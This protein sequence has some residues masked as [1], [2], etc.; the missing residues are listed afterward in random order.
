[1]SLPLCGDR[2]LAHQHYSILV[3]QLGL[4]YLF[5]EATECIESEDMQ[6]KILQL[7][8]KNEGYL[9]V[10]KALRER[11]YERMLAL[12]RRHNSIG[13]P[14]ALAVNTISWLLEHDGSMSAFD[15]ARAVTLKPKTSALAAIDVDDVM[16]RVILVC[17]GFVTLDRHSGVA[18]FIHQTCREFLASVDF[19]RTAE[20]HTRMSC[21]ALTYLTRF[22]PTFEWPTRIRVFPDHP[23]SFLV[24][25][26]IFLLFKATCVD[27]AALL[28]FL[29]SL[30][31]RNRAEFV[32]VAYLL[33][34]RARR[35]YYGTHYE[36]YDTVPPSD[37]LHIL[38]LLSRDGP[39]TDYLS[40]DELGLPMSQHTYAML[41]AAATGRLALLKELHHLH[42]NGFDGARDGFGGTALHW[43]AAGGQLSSV[44]W[45]MDQISHHISTLTDSQGLT[46]V[47]L[48]VKNSHTHVV[49][50]LLSKGLNVQTLGR[51]IWD[52][53][54][55]ECMRKGEPSMMKTLLAAS[56]TQFGYVN[57]RGQTLLHLSAIHGNTS[58]LE[59]LLNETPI[60]DRINDRDLRHRTALY[61]A[62]SYGRADI[63]RIL[64]Q[65][66]PDVTL[67]DQKGW[68]PLHAV[69]LSKNISGQQVQAVVI[70]LVE[71]NASSYVQ[72]HQGKTPYHWTRRSQ[73]TVQRSDDVRLLLINNNTAGTSSQNYLELRTSLLDAAADGHDHIAVDA[74]LE[75]DG[76]DI[77]SSAGIE[78][79]VNIALRTRCMA[80]IIWLIREWQPRAPISP[81]DALWRV[82]GQT[83]LQ[84]ALSHQYEGP[85]LLKAL[86]EVSLG[87]VDLAWQDEKRRS[88]LHFACSQM[89]DPHDL[90]LILLE[91]G[92]A[93]HMEDRDDQGMTALHTAITAG[94]S[95]HTVAILVAQ[96][97]ADVGALDG[98]G[99]SCLKLVYQQAVS[100]PPSSKHGSTW[101]I[102]CICIM[103]CLMAHT[104][105]QDLELFGGP[106]LAEACAGGHSWI[107]ECLLQ[108]QLDDNVPLGQAI[109]DGRD[110]MVHALLHRRFY[111]Q[112]A[113]HPNSP[114]TETSEFEGPGF[115]LP[116]VTSSGLLF[117][118]PARPE[119]APVPQIVAES[120]A[121]EGV[122]ARWYKQSHHD[123]KNATL[124]GLWQ[125]HYSLDKA[126]L[127]HYLRVDLNTLLTLKVFHPRRNPWV[128]HPRRDPSATV[129]PWRQVVF[130]RLTD[131]SPDGFRI[132]PQRAEDTCAGRSL[133][134]TSSEEFTG[135]RQV[136]VSEGALRGVLLTDLRVRAT[137]I[138]LA[139]FPIHK[140]LTF[141][142]TM[143]SRLWIRKA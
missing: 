113:Q 100:M 22:N 125:T 33:L 96:A 69:F 120:R 117:V 56:D 83:P 41:F 14:S 31:A 4:D 34:L 126:Y 137:F 92:A 48:A 37:S 32:R 79:L 39:I 16:E 85:L 111:G 141:D 84:I 135:L 35:P 139:T 15:L 140:F 123:S 67:A 131:R 65:H 21:T 40:V 52:S 116:L 109:V 78:T 143:H 28:R 94:Q 11:L 118:G 58:I 127:A 129:T 98:S 112:F 29:R 66:D 72:D 124:K 71:G 105:S 70:A 73:Y 3:A 17:C 7:S 19:E 110:E 68:T 87:L 64:V 60:A 51:T 20:R 77:C 25:V 132:S 101:R 75:R 23:D 36:A 119:P 42:S 99:N 57:L 90:V 53:V 130:R 2:Y 138:S 89:F 134:R 88:P 30:T 38:S 5:R 76:A 62:A 115:N 46:A 12:V 43:A 136:Q 24:L 9:G 80:S 55:D 93:S 63:I 81:S 47:H 49:K 86:R 74:I 102:R 107:V 103:R 26:T 91:M 54:M 8:A 95:E 27:K 142:C 1:V 61:W 13:G 82:T 97:H 108:W 104:R 133:R 122:Y 114:M 10:G 106:I 6:E 128:I 59:Y 44:N 121:F 45:I 50:T 18:R